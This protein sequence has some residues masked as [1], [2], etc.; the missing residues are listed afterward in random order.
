MECVYLGLLSIVSIT[1]G[2][3]L[4]NRK[5]DANNILPGYTLEGLRYR[6]KVGGNI[7][8][9]MGGIFLIITLFIGVL[10]ITG[11]W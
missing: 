6:H 10:M 11:K 4:R 7:L 2:W 3:K 8:L 9:V 5:I 1:A